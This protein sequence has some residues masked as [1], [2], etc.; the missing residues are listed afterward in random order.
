MTAY[1]IDESI[2]EHHGVKGMKWGVTR[3]S[4][5]EIVR[6]ELR[7]KKF[8]SG[9]QLKKTERVAAKNQV[10]LK[11]A[12]AIRNNRREAG[13][14]VAAR[15]L[16]GE[17]AAISVLALTGGSTGGRKLATA[18]SAGTKIHAGKA[19]VDANRANSRLRAGFAT[20]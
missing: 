4:A 11:S 18:I 15:I 14:K 13:R 6:R 1:Y 9:R 5:S 7:N 20:S 16:G 12:K 8:S 10:S 3:K 2:L 17:I 19:I